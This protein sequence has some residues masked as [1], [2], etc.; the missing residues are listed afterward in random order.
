ME[1]ATQELAGPPPTGVEDGLRGPPPPL[2]GGPLTVLRFMRRHGMLTPKYGRLLVRLPRPKLTPPRPEP[3]APDP[4]PR[5]RRH[6]LH[7]PA[8]RARDRQEGADRARPLVVAR[9]RDQDP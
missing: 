5:A 3:Q 4:P 1:A 8:R 9:A 6:R 2:H 7:R